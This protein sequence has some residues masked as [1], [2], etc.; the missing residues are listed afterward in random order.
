MHKRARS[1]RFRW[2]YVCPWVRTHTMGDGEQPSIGGRARATLAGAPRDDV[3]LDDRQSV[4][5]TICAAI[6]R[7]RSMGRVLACPLHVLILGADR[8]EGDH[9]VATLA[10]CAVAILQGSE[11]ET[12]EGRARLTFTL[13]GP[14]LPTAA[15]LSV[16]PGCIVRCLPAL[17]HEEGVWQAVM[18]AGVHVPDVAFAMNAGIWGYSTWAETLRLLQR[19]AL[20][21]VVSSYNELEADEDAGALEEMGFA[22]NDDWLWNPEP[23]PF[24][25]SRV[26]LNA[27][28][29]RSQSNSWWQCLGTSRGG[30][31]PTTW[32]IVRNA[33]RRPKVES[34]HRPRAWTSVDTRPTM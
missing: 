17:L 27:L 7:L 9:L 10:P 14:N 13:V 32:D 23:N 4:S 1:A 24:C 18:G 33:A 11:P 31:V 5:L 20:P 21:L 25:S 28:G 6:A 12:E 8:L 26:W 15:E 29:R 34:D 30:D 19:A 2:S 3:P 22:E 16:L